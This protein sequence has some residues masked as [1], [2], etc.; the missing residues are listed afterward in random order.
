[1][2]SVSVLQTTPGGV[3]VYEKFFSAHFMPEQLLFVSQAGSSYSDGFILKE[4]IWLKKSNFLKSRHRISRCKLKL[5]WFKLIQIQTIKNK[6]LRLLL[7]LKEM[8]TLITWS[9]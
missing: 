8:Y 4:E 9:A 5:D 1:M 6:K 7:Q 3:W 2:N